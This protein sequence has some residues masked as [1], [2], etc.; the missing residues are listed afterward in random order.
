[1]LPRP[2]RHAQ[3][4]H[5]LAAHAHIAASTARRKGDHLT[6]YELTIKANALSRQALRL[7][8]RQS[9]PYLH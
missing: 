8:E 3:D 4:L 1:M 7:A 5:I 2:D 9:L 6:A